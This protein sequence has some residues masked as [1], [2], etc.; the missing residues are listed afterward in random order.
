MAIE[1]II[2]GTPYE[3]RE[4]QTVLEVARDHGITIPTLCYHKDLSPSG[5]CRL[6]LVEVEGVRGQLAGCTLAASDGMIVHTETSALAESR[7]FVLDMLLRRYV[8]TRNPTDATRDSELL[9]WAARYG[10]TAPDPPPA[11]RYIP[12]S[13]PNPFVRVD[14][15]KCILCT[16]CVR[17]CAEI[18]GRFV[19]DVGYRGDDAKIIAGLDSTMLDGRCESCGLCAE[20][21]P[22]GALDHKMSYGLGKPDRIVTTTCTYCGVGCQIELN[23]KDGKIIRVTSSPDA[24]VNGIALCVKGRYGYDFVHHPDRLRRPRVRKYL[25]SGEPKP[26]S[27]IQNPKSK[28]QNSKP[29]PQNPNWEWV[30]VDW[31][32]A[33]SITARKLRDTRDRD[34]ADSIGVLASAKCTNEENYL[35]NKFARQVI[36]TNNIDHCA[37]L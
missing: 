1:L 30:E 5:N 29:K 2:D 36:G 22:T 17:A 19:W 34:G 13:D 31:E 3:A 10:V 18:Q 32:T 7:K 25:L 21:C 9:Y 37:R 28:A 6:C 12:D 8:E 35:M 15:N 14:L 27:E 4:G 24:P 20:V 16:R 26:K 23:V 11:P 33:L